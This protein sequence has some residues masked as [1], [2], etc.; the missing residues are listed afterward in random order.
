[1]ALDTEAACL[2]INRMWLR[3]ARSLERKAFEYAKQG[4][5]VTAID[6][7]KAAEACFW[8]ATGETPATDLKDL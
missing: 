8:Q 1:M 5:V 4:S 2:R 3:V 7:T 6:L